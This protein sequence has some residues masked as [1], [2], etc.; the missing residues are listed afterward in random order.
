MNGKIYSQLYKNGVELDDQDEELLYSSLNV[1]VSITLNPSNPPLSAY[2][3]GLNK[4]NQTYTTNNYT[5][6]TRHTIKSI[7]THRPTN[8]FIGAGAEEEEGGEEEGGEEGEEEEEANIVEGDDI[9]SVKRTYNNTNDVFT[10]HHVT[11][12][13]KNHTQSEINDINKYRGNYVYGFHTD[14]SYVYLNDKNNY[15]IKFQLKS[16]SVYNIN[17]EGGQNKIF[18]F[19]NIDKKSS[20]GEVDMFNNKYVAGREYLADL[21]EEI[22]NRIQH[23]EEEGETEEEINTLIREKAKRKEKELIDEGLQIAEKTNPDKYEKFRL[24]E[25]FNNFDIITGYVSLDPPDIKKIKKFKT[26]NDY[27]KILYKNKNDNI[28]GRNTNFI[29]LY[30]MQNTLFSSFM[31]FKHI[32]KYVLSSDTDVISGRLKQQN[33]T[34]TFRITLYYEEDEYFVISTTSPIKGILDKFTYKSPS[35]LNKIIHLSLVLPPLSSPLPMDTSSRRA[36]LYVATQ[37]SDINNDCFGF[38][39]DHTNN[40]Y[41]QLLIPDEIGNNN[42]NIDFPSRST[43]LNNIQDAITNI[44]ITNSGLNKIYL[45]KSYFKESF[46]NLWSTFKNDIKNEIDDMKMSISDQFNKGTILCALLGTCDS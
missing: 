46:Y 10:Y 16:E 41:T 35:V 32:T 38:F 6:F 18:D 29:D 24:Q 12:L 8:F 44:S 45:K 19:K 40:N 22:R 3:Y 11:H 25:I 23:E 13:Y 37:I 17:G 9:Y 20:D 27:R 30:R 26:F 33:P 1:E 15:Y 34:S 36:M 14:N 31:T 5:V 7:W 28:Y 4:S 42:T 39:Y 21:K 43:Y 2:M